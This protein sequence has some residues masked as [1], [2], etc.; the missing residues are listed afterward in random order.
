MNADPLSPACAFDDELL[1]AS[2]GPGSPSLAPSGG[3]PL[4]GEPPASPAC[5]WLL[6][7]GTDGSLD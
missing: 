4:E 7:P 3:A 2:G 6:E 1:D 5:G